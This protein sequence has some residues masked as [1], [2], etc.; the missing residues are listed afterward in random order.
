M[1]ARRVDLRRYDWR[2]R[3]PV[4]PSRLRATV[5]SVPLQPGSAR[6]RTLVES[7]SSELV[8]LPLTAWE[9]GS[10]PQLPDGPS[11]FHLQ[12]GPALGSPGA[13]AGLE[14][15]V[16]HQ[17]GGQ[18]RLGGVLASAF[19]VGAGLLGTFKFSHH[20]H[21]PSPAIQ[22]QHQHQPS[23]N[24][25]CDNASYRVVVKGLGTFSCYNNYMLCA[26]RENVRARSG[27]N[28]YQSRSHDLWDKFQ[29]AVVGLRTTIK[30]EF[31]INP[32]CVRHPQLTTKALTFL[33]PSRLLLAGLAA[34]V[35][36]R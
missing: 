24:T 21:Q 30:Y 9:S 1:G 15:R 27:G 28:I 4:V 2:D 10:P 31:Q 26:I 14:G 5:R 3:D 18:L 34:Q 29:G 13:R 25:F 35:D 22:S 12:F 33:A 16:R 19:S 17:R 8:V 20:Q 11:S 32:F 7:F 36:A 6:H 23:R